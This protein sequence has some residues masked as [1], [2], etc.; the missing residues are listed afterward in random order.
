M[1]RSFRWNPTHIFVVFIFSENRCAMHYAS[2]TEPS[3]GLKIRGARSTVVGIICPPPWLRLTVWPKTGGLKPHP[4]TPRLRQPWIIR[5][6]CCIC[7]LKI[8]MGF[9]SRKIEEIFLENCTNKNE[10]VWIPKK[11]FYWLL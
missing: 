10:N 11:W 8:E 3:Q 6:F 2:I 1:Y 4:P 9:C 7:F 5:I